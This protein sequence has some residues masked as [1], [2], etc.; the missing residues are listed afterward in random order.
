[1]KR[2]FMHIPETLFLSFKSTVAGENK[3][4]VE[5]IRQFMADYVQEKQREKTA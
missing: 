4:M 3:T 1:M 2:L 5:V